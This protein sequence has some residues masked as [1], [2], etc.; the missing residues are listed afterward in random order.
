MNTIIAV[1]IVWLYASIPFSLLIGF[2]YGKDIRKIGSGNVGGTNLGRTFGKRAFTYGFIMDM[3]KGFMAVIIGTLLGV[4]PILLAMVAILSHS[5]SFFIKFKGGKGVAT[6]FG[7]SIFYSPL[8]SLFAITI[9]IVVLYIS[10]YVSL[11]SIIAIFCYVLYSFFFQSLLYFLL[12]F[13]VWLFVVYAHRKNIVK[14]YNGEESRVTWFE[15]K[16][17]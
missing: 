17:K 15:R 16:K 10:R 9:F 4:E 5:F 8:G 13:L 12:I 11:S 6:A 2:L 3:T 1:I 14:I 7:F